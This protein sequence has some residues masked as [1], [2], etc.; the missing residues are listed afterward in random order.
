MNCSPDGEIDVH[1]P[2]SLTRVGRARYGD[3][4]AVTPPLRGDEAGV[5]QELLQ[6]ADETWSI[7]NDVQAAV[8]LRSSRNEVAFSY[9]R[10]NGSRVK[11]DMPRR[12]LGG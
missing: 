10:Q 12:D 11:G 2:P 6:V 5:P 3:V 1:D 4:E 7:D 8:A 9:C